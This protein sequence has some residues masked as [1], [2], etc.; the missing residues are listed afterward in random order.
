MICLNNCIEGDIVFYADNS[1]GCAL[2]KIIKMNEDIIEIDSLNDCV[3]KINKSDISDS[4][5]GS[6]MAG[7][8]GSWYWRELYDLLW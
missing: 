7:V 5:W 3:T 4:T 6:D 1:Y 2:H 8:V